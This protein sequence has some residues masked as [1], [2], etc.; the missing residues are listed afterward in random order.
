MLCSLAVLPFL[1]TALCLLAWPASAQVGSAPLIAAQKQGLAALAYLD[2][3]WRGSAWY[4]DQTG[5][6]YDMIHTERIGP[7]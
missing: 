5:K 7:Q 4:R 1:L 3:E 6:R 2:G